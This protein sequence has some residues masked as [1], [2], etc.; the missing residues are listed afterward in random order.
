[1][2]NEVICL[3]P[4]HGPLRM[5]KVSSGKKVRLPNDYCMMVDLYKCPSCGREVLSD[6]GPAHA[7]RS[8]G[9]YDYDMSEG[10]Y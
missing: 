10:F 8:P 5:R 6:N 7:D 2:A 4:A 9:H 1:M 3:N